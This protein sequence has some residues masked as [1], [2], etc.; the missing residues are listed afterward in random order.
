MTLDQT[1][2]ALA[3][4]GHPLRLIAT[5]GGTGGHTYPA[6]T[7]IRVARELLADAGVGLDV[8]YVAPLLGWRPALPSRKG[9]RSRRCPPASYGAQRTPYG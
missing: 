9:S 8:L 4:R 5:G 2:H 1:L 7:T 6:I 3:A